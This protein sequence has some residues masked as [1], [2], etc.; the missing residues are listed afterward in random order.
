MMSAA[1]PTECASG[2]N[3]YEIFV[4]S[5][6]TS[7]QSSDETES[8]STPS[9]PNSAETVEIPN[10]FKSDWEKIKAST[11]NTSVAPIDYE[12][13]NASYATREIEMPRDDNVG[14]TLEEPKSKPSSSST[15]HSECQFRI[16]AMRE[17]AIVKDRLISFLKA[18]LE[19]FQVNG[20]TPIQK[21]LKP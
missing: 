9:S 7:E 15:D 8:T 12:N 13:L 16:N 14:P 2:G 1:K 11:P 20:R 17:S 19:K 6:S 4:R 3:V 5:T 18:D 10:E 21:V